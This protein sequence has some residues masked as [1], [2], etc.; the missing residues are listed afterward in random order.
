MVW[1][2]CH[3][4]WAAIKGFNLTYGSTDESRWQRSLKTLRTLLLVPRSSTLRGEI[5]SGCNI[6]TARPS[7]DI[8]ISY[9][10]IQGKGLQVL[11]T[12]ATGWGDIF[13]C[14]EQSTFHLFVPHSED[15]KDVILWKVWSHCRVF[16]K[17]SV[18]AISQ[19]LGTRSNSR[20]ISGS[21]LSESDL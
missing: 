20:H 16:R 10:L 13:A 15:G 1:S 8:Y 14:Q 5:G 17:P 6:E 18:H 4:K 11:I 2:R 9:R 7:M 19:F 3:H 21:M 12:F